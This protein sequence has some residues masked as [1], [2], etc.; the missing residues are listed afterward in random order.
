M[1]NQ[2]TNKKRNNK[3]NWNRS[4]KRAAERKAKG[5]V[6]QPATTVFKKEINKEMDAVIKDIAQTFLKLADRA[7]KSLSIIDEH[8]LHEIPD[9]R[10]AVG[11]LAG[12]GYALGAINQKFPLTDYIPKEKVDAIFDIMDDN[13]YSDIDEGMIFDEL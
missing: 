3:G 6:K 4:K 12:L 7:D 11:N 2:V 13:D 9:F 8:V 5:A 1:D 10:E